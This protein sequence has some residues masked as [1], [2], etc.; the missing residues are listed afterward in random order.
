MLTNELNTSPLSLNPLSPRSVAD[1]LFSPSPSP[2]LST[3]HILLLGIN[4][5][6]PYSPKGIRRLLSSEK[7]GRFSHEKKQE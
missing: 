5:G 1:S 4:R 7:L 6:F 3:K 2:I